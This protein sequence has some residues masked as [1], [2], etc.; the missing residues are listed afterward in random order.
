VAHL[1]IYINQT[2]DIWWSKASNGGPFLRLAVP[3]PRGGE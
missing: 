3:M 1:V 2:G